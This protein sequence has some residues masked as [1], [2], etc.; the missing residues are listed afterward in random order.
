MKYMTGLN[1]K[2]CGRLVKN[3]KLR[4]EHSLEVPARPGCLRLV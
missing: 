3:N 1:I 2:P 4:L